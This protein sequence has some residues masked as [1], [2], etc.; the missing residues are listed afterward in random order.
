MPD[1]KGEELRSLLGL[2]LENGNR[3]IL[4]NLKVDCMQT[5]HY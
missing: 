1:S 3:V 5:V 4:T 2:F